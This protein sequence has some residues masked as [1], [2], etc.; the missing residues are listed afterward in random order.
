MSYLVY[1]TGWAKH[2]N[3]LYPFLR[4]ETIKEAVNCMRELL[5]EGRAVKVFSKPVNVDQ[6]RVINLRNKRVIRRK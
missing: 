6:F 4:T 2:Y 5:Q 1:S 3:T